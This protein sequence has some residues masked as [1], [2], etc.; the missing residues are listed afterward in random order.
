MQKDDLLK[1]MDF[2]LSAAIGKC[3]NLAEAQDLTQ[4]TMLAALCACEKNTPVTNAKGWLLQVLHHKYYDML[5]RK[6]QKPTVVIG[7]G[8]DVADERDFLEDMLHR[9]EHEAVRR[10]VAFLAEGYRKVILKHYFYGESVEVIARDMNIPQGTVKSRLNFG[11]KQIGKGLE[12]MTVYEENSYQPQCL[13]VSFYGTSG[14]NAEPMSLVEGDR[15]AQN[16]LILAYEKPVT[17]AELSK[18]IGVATAYVEPIVNKLVA[19]ELF[20]ISMRREVHVNLHN[21]RFF[22]F[23]YV[24]EK[25]IIKAQGSL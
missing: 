9:E 6:Y 18:A 14:M 25:D 13:N 20:G 24:E 16:L 1:Y 19:G 17:I 12:K 5:R 8:F 10:E 23:T 7:D 21:V 4:E 11:R 22:A 2:I 3:G 15:L